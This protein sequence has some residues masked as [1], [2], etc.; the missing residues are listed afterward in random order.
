MHHF[1]DRWCGPCR[2]LAPII[3]KNIQEA[4]GKI[5]LVKVDVDHCGE[6]ARELGVKAIPHVALIH[7]GKTIDCKWRGII[8]GR[9][10]GS[11]E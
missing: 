6:V 7:K 2:T 4:Q 9:S 10:F 8:P 1:R 11:A 3:E 5:T